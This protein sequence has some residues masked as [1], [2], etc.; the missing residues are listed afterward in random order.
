MNA[1]AA[2]KIIKTL[3]LARTVAP[4]VIAAGLALLVASG[5]IEPTGDEIDHDVSVL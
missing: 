4:V 5:I 1:E 2:L 3:K